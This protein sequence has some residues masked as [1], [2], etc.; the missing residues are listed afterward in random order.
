[1]LLSMK[2]ISLS[3]FQYTA[4]FVEWHWDYHICNQGWS[5]KVCVCVIAVKPILSAI[6]II[7]LQWRHNA[8]N[9]VSNHQP[10]VVYPTVYSG[11]DQTKH[12]SSASLVFVRGTGEFPAQKT[13][14]GEK[15]SIWWRHHA[16]AR[17]H[18]HA[19]RNN[20]HIGFDLCTPGAPFAYMD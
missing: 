7:L 9:G 2:R 3:R 1:M 11:A 12:Q 10:T 8:P 18:R 20:D 15:V 16:F 13:S 5:K 6:K 4:M 19:K 14:N 17:L